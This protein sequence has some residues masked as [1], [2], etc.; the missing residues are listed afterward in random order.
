MEHRWSRINT[1]SLI[2]LKT[3]TIKTHKQ[4]VGIGVTQSLGACITS[5]KVETTVGPKINVI[6]RGVLIRSVANLSSRSGGVSAIRNLNWSSALPIATTGVVSILQMVF[7]NMITVT[8]VNMTTYWPLMNSMVVGRYKN[9]NV[10]HPRRGYRESIAINLP[11][12]LS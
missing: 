11:I 2:V 6:G 8:H 9:A 1:T 3:I 10:V 7:I 5:A 4:H 12:F